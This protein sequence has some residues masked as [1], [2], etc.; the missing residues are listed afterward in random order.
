MLMTEAGIEAPKARASQA[1]R[2]IPPLLLDNLKKLARVLV[3]T[4]GNQCEVVI[5]DLYDLEQSLV[6]IEGNVTGRKPGAPMTDL[7]IEKIQKGETDDLLNYRTEMPDGKELKSSSTFIVNDAGEVI[8]AFCIN[9]DVTIL[10]TAQ[11]ILDSMTQFTLDTSLNETFVE[12][13]TEIIERTVDSYVLERGKPLSLMNKTDKVGLVQY[14]NQKG[15]MQLQR[16]VPILADLLG[17]TRQ[18]IYNYLEVGNPS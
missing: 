10:N 16:A 17:V 4:L 6:W 7:G 15:I 5:H 2:L 14:L 9:W 1:E 13:A 8:G 18:T 11:Q 3:A 12:D